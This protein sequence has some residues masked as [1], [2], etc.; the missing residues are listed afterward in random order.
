MLVITSRSLS[1]LTGICNFTIT[2]GITDL[3][4]QVDQKYQQ[5]CQNSSN[6]PLQPRSGPRVGTDTDAKYNTE[7]REWIVITCCCNDHGLSSVAPF[8]FLNKASLDRNNY[9]QNKICRWRFSVFISRILYFMYIV[10]TKSAQ[11]P[12]RN[13]HITMILTVDPVPWK[14]TPKRKP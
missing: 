13:H 10:S 12:R 2:P 6:I 4:L 1:Y 11:K 9:L 5:S 7:S 8:P 14:I 3:E